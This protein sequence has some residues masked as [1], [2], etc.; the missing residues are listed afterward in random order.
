MS[1]DFQA[2]SHDEVVSIQL[3]S[4]NDVNEVR[5]A[6]EQDSFECSWKGMCGPK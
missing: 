2:A 1:F 3:L 6:T 4:G 5:P